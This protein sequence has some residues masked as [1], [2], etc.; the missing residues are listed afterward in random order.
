MA[1]ADGFEPPI[2]RVRVCCLSR[3]AKPLS[4]RPFT[5]PLYTSALS[6]EGLYLIG[7]S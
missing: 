6:A 5:G 4:K 2:S 1:G 7:R 3:L